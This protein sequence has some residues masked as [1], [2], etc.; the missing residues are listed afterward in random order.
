[1]YPF[2][3]AGI[4]LGSAL[5]LSNA[6]SKGYSHRSLPQRAVATG[7]SSPLQPGC[8]ADRAD[9]SL[10]WFVSV[11]RQIDYRLIL[12]GSLLT[13]VIDRPLTLLLFGQPLNPGRLFCHSLL[14]LVI[15]SLT[16]VYFYNRRGTTWPIALSFGIFFHLILDRMWLMPQ[17]L[18]WPI[19][20]WVWAKQAP[21]GFGT[22]AP[23]LWQDTFHVLLY[24]VRST[25]AIYI[26]EIIG[27]CILLGFAVLLVR[28][29]RVCAFLKTGA[30]QVF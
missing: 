10:P 6:L 13:D 12:V 24:D 17:T 19:Y 11:A 30:A 21:S 25:P 7:I 5:L 20:G 3:H 16:A 8:A 18:F 28:R 14:F 15:L 29:K 26:P 9:S 22:I 2:A 1:M 23:S 27:A 4:T